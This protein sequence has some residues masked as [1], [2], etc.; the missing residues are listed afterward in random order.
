MRIKDPIDDPERKLVTNFTKNLNRTDADA[1]VTSKSTQSADR[2]PTA[3]A[4][5]FLRRFATVRTAKIF[6]PLL[7]KP[8][9]PLTGSLSRGRVE[10]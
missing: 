2:A 8:S 6:E 9:H 3:A 10:S 4:T 7:R 1:A 5:K